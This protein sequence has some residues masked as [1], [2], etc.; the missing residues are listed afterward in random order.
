MIQ[1]LSAVTASAAVRLCSGDGEG[2]RWRELLWGPALGGPRPLP[3]W[4]V[5]L[6]RLLCRSK[7]RSRQAGHQRPTW[8]TVLGHQGRAQRAESVKGFPQQPLLSIAPHLPV[9]GT[10]VMCHSEASHMGHGICSLWGAG[11]LARLEVSS[12]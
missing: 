1:V 12:W 6:L 10:H 8:H 4:R 2:G 3:F 11:D 9:T 7:E 5:A